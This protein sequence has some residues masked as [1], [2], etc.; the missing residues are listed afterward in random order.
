LV[1]AAGHGQFW[2]SQLPDLGLWIHGPPRRSARFLDD[3]RK[4]H[5]ALVLAG[6]DVGAKIFVK[7]NC[8][9]AGHQKLP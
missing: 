3:R 5:A 8:E 2:R 1:T 4:E 9:A 7:L 6:V